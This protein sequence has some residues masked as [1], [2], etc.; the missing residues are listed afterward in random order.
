MEA[1]HQASKLASI[2]MKASL[3]LDIISPLVK[4]LQHGITKHQPAERVWKIQ[5]DI[6]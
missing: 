1:T 3:S 5:L 6:L 4:F 2:A